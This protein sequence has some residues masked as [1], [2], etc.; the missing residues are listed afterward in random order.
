MKRFGSNTHIRQ[1]SLQNNEI[2][3]DI[4]LHN[5]KAFNPR[6]CNNYKYLLTQHW[7]TQVCKA[8]VHEH[9]DIK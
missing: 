2:K 6:G 3:K 8:K 9:R 4:T 7:I 5:F 1:H